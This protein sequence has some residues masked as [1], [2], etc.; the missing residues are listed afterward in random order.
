MKNKNWGQLLVLNLYDCENKILKSE[1]KLKKFCLELC[2]KIQMNPYGK[3][4]I[5]RFGKGELEGYSLMQFIET[6]SITIHADEFGN[7][8]FIDI[9]SCKEFDPKI[10]EEFSKSFFRAK[11]AKANLVE[12]K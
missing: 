3:P 8:V 11:S 12:R 6:S 4:L 1:L 9:F 10:A 7:R 2:K 5:K